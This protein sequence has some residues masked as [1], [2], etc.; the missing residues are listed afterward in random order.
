MS[1]QSRVVDNADQNTG[2]ALDMMAQM[3]VVDDVDQSNM[4]VALDMLDME[5][6]ANKVDWRMGVRT[7]DCMEDVYAVV[8]RAGQG[9]MDV[10]RHVAQK[11]C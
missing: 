4:E 11:T 10:E 8:N 5:A 3:H 2:V 1:A 6:V 9:W 7:K